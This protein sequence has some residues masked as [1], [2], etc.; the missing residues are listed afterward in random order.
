MMSPKEKARHIKELENHPGW[1]LVLEHLNLE[2]EGHVS[3]WLE[4][5][6]ISNQENDYRR[7]LVS[8]GRR[9]RQIPTILSNH[10]A[11][12]AASEAASDPAKAGKEPTE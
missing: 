6:P 3:N 11:L 10:Y 1:A 5:R 7:G 8:M 12:Q 4:N 2:L 9:V